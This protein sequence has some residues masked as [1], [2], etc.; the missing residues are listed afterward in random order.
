MSTK[1]QRRPPLAGIGV[2]GACDLLTSSYW[3][4]TMSRW[5]VPDA[6]GVNAIVPALQRHFSRHNSRVSRGDHRQLQPGSPPGGLGE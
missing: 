4:M 6:R 2:G 5:V 1:I 3:Q